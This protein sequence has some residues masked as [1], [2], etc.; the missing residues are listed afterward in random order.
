V[1][2]VLIVAA[3]VRGIEYGMPVLHDVLVPV[4]L[5]IGVIAVVIIARWLRSRST[6]TRSADR[7]QA[8]RRDADE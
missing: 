8:D 7:R 3:I 1:L 2:G 5:V 4:Y 6:S